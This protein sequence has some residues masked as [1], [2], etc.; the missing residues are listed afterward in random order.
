MFN[1]RFLNWFPTSFFALIITIGVFS[2]LVS[3]GVNYNE[4]VSFRDRVWGF[5]HTSIWNIQPRSGLYI[6]DTICLWN[7]TTGW[8]CMSGGWGNFTGGSSGGGGNKSYFFNNTAATHDGSLGGYSG[9]NAVCAAEFAG[10][11]LC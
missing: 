2:F 4:D 9:A 11:H 5:N 1:L 10:T 7:A 6:N 8:Q 3:A